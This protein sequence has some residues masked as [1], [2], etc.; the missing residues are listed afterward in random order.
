MTGVLLQQLVTPVTA[1]VLSV[2][3]VRLEDALVVVT[4]E[5]SLLAPD[6]PAGLGLVALVLAVRSAVAVPALGDADAALLALELGVLVALVGGEDGTALLV[7][8]VVTVGDPVTL[9]A[10]VYALLQVGALEL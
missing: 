2:A 9:V 3:D 1:V 10:L 8:T 5:V 7:T 4:L 6:G